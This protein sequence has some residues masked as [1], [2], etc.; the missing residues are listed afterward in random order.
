MTD[1]TTRRPSARPDASCEAPTTQQ[2]RFARLN[3][4]GQTSI[5]PSALEIALRMFRAG[6]PWA[7]IVAA[8]ND[9]IGPFVSKRKIQSAIYRTGVRRETRRGATSAKPA[10]NVPRNDEEKRASAA[11]ELCLTLLTTG[12]EF[13]RGKPRAAAWSE[14]RGDTVLR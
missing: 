10:G 12:G 5:L 8:V 13:S 11:H 14:G 3:S 9:G 7:D 2:G 4:R 6:A 1:D